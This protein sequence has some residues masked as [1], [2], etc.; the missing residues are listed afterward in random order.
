MGMGPRGWGAPGCAL[1]TTYAEFYRGLLFMKSYSVRS[2]SALI[3]FALAAVPACAAT[4]SSSSGAADVAAFSDG[5]CNYQGRCAP[6][7]SAQFGGATKVVGGYVLD[8]LS[9]IYL[10]FCSDS[11]RAA[12]ADEGRF[13]L[14]LPDVQAP[15]L[16]TLGAA[17]AATACGDDPAVVI[18]PGTRAAGK[19]C[20]DSAQCASTRC[21]GE[22]G[23]CGVCVVL[24]AVGASCT[25]ATRCV[26]GSSCENRVCVASAARKKAGDACTSSGSDPCDSRKLIQC[27]SNVCTDMSA[28]V[29]TSCAT[30]MCVG[31]V[32]DSTTKTCV[33]F[34]TSGACKSSYECDVFRGYACAD[35]TKTCTRYT[36]TVVRAKLGEA[37]DSQADGTRTTCAPALAC[38]A[39][40]KK[41]VDALSTCK[42]P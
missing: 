13:M 23:A 41:C 25:E 33:A 5:M 15:N 34:K 32:C 14:G 21:D 20:L 2:L 17:F 3:V 18:M 35:A 37:C 24:A 10:E 9:G 7:Y 28:K 16:A 26:E 39:T 6:D 1:P 29:G 31:S 11:G 42:A 8:R 27:V 19:D 40:T 4:S 38:D 12:F 36:G 30:K 22:S